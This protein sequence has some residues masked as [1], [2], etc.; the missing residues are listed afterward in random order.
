LVHAFQY[1]VV[2]LTKQ[3]L[4]AQILFLVEYITKTRYGTIVV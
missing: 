3:D 4:W 1:I 2:E